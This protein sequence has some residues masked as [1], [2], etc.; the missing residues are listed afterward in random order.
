[1]KNILF[2]GWVGDSYFSGYLFRARLTIL[3]P[4]L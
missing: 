3:V 4:K 1:L 2:F